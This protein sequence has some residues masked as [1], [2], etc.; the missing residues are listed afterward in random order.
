MPVR[1]G[2]LSCSFTQARWRQ[3]RSCAG[4][5]ESITWAYR[6]R[7]APF[8]PDVLHPNADDDRAERTLHLAL[9]E[10]RQMLAS[11]ADL[12]RTTLRR[13]FPR[14]VFTH[15][16]YRPKADSM[17]QRW[18][19]VLAMTRCGKR[20]QCLLTRLIKGL[21]S[22]LLC[23]LCSA[24]RAKTHVKAQEDKEP[25]EAGYCTPLHV[26]ALSRPMGSAAVQLLA[27]T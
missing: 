6:A 12:N 7:V 17:W 22:L 11:G 5:L 21:S 27:L 1:H 3:L 10:W 23:R 18:T 25:S 13:R 4:A 15:D 8:E 20:L 14:W 2:Y 9:V 24:I 19:N 26:Q 16:Q